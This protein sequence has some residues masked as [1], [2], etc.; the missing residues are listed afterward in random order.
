MRYGLSAWQEWGKTVR[1]DGRVDQWHDQDRRAGTTWDVRL[2]LRDLLYDRGEVAL[3]IYDTDGVFTSGLGGRIGLNRYF[4][5]GFVSVAYDLAGYRFAADPG[6]FL[7]HGF[8]GTVDYD[9]SATTAVSLS[10]DY[11]FGDRQNSFGLGLFL[12][13]R[14]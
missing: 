5:R 14:F 13:K 9:L 11:W 7:Q 4:S 2:A 1:L 6:D 12:Q 10:T 3:S 8:H